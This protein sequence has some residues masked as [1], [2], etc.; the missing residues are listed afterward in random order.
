MEGEWH[1]FHYTVA[2]AI[3][4]GASFAIALIF[5]R[6]KMSKLP[7]G[8]LGWCPFLGRTLGFV[9]PHPSTSNGHFLDQNIIKSLFLFSSLLFSHSIHSTESLISFLVFF[10]YGKIFRSHL[11]GHRTIVSCD[12]EFNNFVLQNEDRF[13]VSSYPA[14]IPGILGRLTLLVATG[15]VHKRLRAVALS[16]FAAIRNEQQTFLD[17]LQ[18]CALLLVKSWKNTETIIFCNEAR[19]YTFTVIVKEILSLKA[20]DPETSMI[21]ENFLTFMKGLCSIPIKLP[22]TAYEMAIQ[23]RRRIFEIVRTIVRRRKNTGDHGERK[24][25]DFLDVMMEMEG[26][27]EDEILSLVMD[28]LLGGHETTAMLISILVK[29]LSESPPAL[30]QL[31]EEHRGVRKRKEKGEGLMW[32]DYKNMKFTQMLIK[33]GLRYGNVVKFVHRKALQTIN[34]KGYEIPK[35]WKVLPI[36]SGV[37][38]D[39]SQYHEPL[40]FNPWRW[41]GKD[42]RGELYGKYFMAFGGGLRLC[43]GSELAKLETAI[44]LH[45]FVLN[46]EWTPLNPKDV[47]M[48]FPFV[49]FKHGLQLSLKPLSHPTTTLSS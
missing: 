6:Q 19:K 14:N 32:E 16:L 30:H 42:K 48:A 45:Y 10:R 36:L 39:A 15:T 46:F 33:E 3:F 7:P 35:G 11:F 49:D 13:F 31:R 22:G 26:I 21:L 5:R 41:Q 17:D 38:L 40:Q 28:L 25:K 34:F 44:F 8:N 27:S 9:N 20:D 47:P 43:P 37:H 4:M 23:S 18:N 12:Q 1:H 2:V 29:C 24:R